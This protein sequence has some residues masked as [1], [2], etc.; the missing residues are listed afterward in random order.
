[1]RKSNT[2]R[3]REL[4]AASAAAASAADVVRGEGSI[5]PCTMSV[6]GGPDGRWTIAS[7]PA[8][9]DEPQHRLDLTFLDVLPDALR[10]PMAR[11]FALA[12][13]RKARIVT[14]TSLRKAMSAGLLRYASE[15]LPPDAK[16]ID[17]GFVSGF[18]HWLNRMENGR[19]ALEE[20]TR[21]GYF[22][23]VRSVLFAG[24]QLGLPEFALDGVD[25]R[26]RPFAGQH[27]APPGDGA[28]LSGGAMTAILRA[29]VAE[30]SAAM[31]R[32][33]PRISGRETPGSDADDA[34]VAELTFALAGHEASLSSRPQ[35]GVLR[36][37]HSPAALEARL[38]TFRD[39]VPFVLLLAHYT[40]FNPSTLF[41]LRRKDVRSY[42]MGSASWTALEAYKPRSDKMQ[43]AV[44]AEDGSP[45][46]PA[47]LVRFVCDWTAPIAAALDSD[48]VWVASDPT[49][50]YE[51]NDKRSGSSAR[52]TNITSRWLAARG[53]PDA[54]LSKIRKGVL[55]LVHLETGGDRAAVAAAGGNSEATVDGHY[56]SPAALRRER[57]RL[58][59][60]AEGLE[61]WLCSN[62]LVDGR[63]L[64]DS[65][66]LTAATPGFSCMD[67]YS[68]PMPQPLN[69]PGDGSPCAAYGRCPICPL[70]I[71]DLGSPRAC[72]Y[73]HLLLDRIDAGVEGND[74][75]STAA[76]V[77]VWL[78]VARRLRTHW[79]PA[80][81]EDVHDAAR[82]LELPPL[83]EIE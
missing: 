77:S 62:G 48:L 52:V 46:N 16:S 51:L 32:I 50:L 59:S 5:V 79:L 80:F 70:A 18:V 33:L 12:A 14:R 6:G 30:A 66:D 56:T 38:P 47:A 73:L 2:A 58:A 9:G 75:V 83:P 64:P 28:F 7:F 11:A 19:P 41:G 63:M 53:L 40:G 35:V 26:A 25:W 10:N 72:G 24:W 17:P 20:R 81:A 13:S 71:V 61:R 4:R 21:N 78:P 8:H 60:A 43:R 3:R 65:S 74:A 22:V 15:F 39:M 68:S 1:M 54:N 29:C 44:F 34:E 42:R 36:K 27:A 45:T 67:R 69:R 76:Y 23:N 49:G 82:S 55:D 37:R 31:D 57:L